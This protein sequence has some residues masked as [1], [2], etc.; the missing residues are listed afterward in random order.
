LK[1]KKRCR[2]RAARGWKRRRH[3][4]IDRAAVLPQGKLTR[5]LVDTGQDVPDSIRLSLFGNLYGSVPIFLGGI[6]NTLLVSGAIA[7]R[8]PEALFILW[9]TAELMLAAIRFPVMLA[10][11][12]AV[13]EGR[14]GPSEL[15]LLLALCWASAVGF[16]AFICLTS[17]DWVIATLACLSAGAMVGGICFRNFAAPRLAVLIIALSLGP[18]A[19]GGLFS[20]QPLLLVALIQIPLYLFAMSKAAFDMNRTLVARMRAELDKDH[21]ARHDELTGLMNRN[22]LADALEARRPRER[23]HVYLF[24]DLDGF[25]PVNDRLGHAA[26]DQLLAEIGQ[27]LRAAAPPGAILARLGGDEFLMITDCSGPGE[28][29]AT[30]DMLI[31]ALSSQPYLVAGTGVDIGVSVGIALSHVYGREFVALI[32]AA[33]AALY[34]A[35]AGGRNRYVL[36]DQRPRLAAVNGVV[37]QRAR[38]SAR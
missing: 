32:A 15:Y 33:D 38:V 24:L 11:R 16:G 10:G 4:A 22:G 5:W 34:E 8:R 23:E 6:I 3:D 26:G 21:R 2:L 29:R 19:V 36:A 14:A 27:R 35:K 13:S 17:G 18:V 31:A 9:A 37:P 1:R 12:R 30:A 28:A 7:V 20:D 25:K